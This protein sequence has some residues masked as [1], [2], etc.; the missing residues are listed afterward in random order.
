MD[1]TMTDVNLG[2]ANAKDNGGKEEPDTIQFQN[3]NATP[4][5]TAS[6][7]P[8]LPLRSQIGTLYNAGAV[9][10]MNEK[11]P[12]T[13]KELWAIILDC[14]VAIS[15]CPHVPITTM[16][17]EMKNEYITMTGEGLQLHG[18]KETTML[19]GDLDASEMHRGQ[20]AIAT[21]RP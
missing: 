6:G 13:Y 8:T 14:G 2:K 5:Q 15:F 16:T 4:Q 21:H 20:C 11:T 17:D 7:T 3:F 12:E 9:N 10:N 1:G 19:V 18:W